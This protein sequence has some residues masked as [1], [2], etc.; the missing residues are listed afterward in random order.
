MNISL[1]ELTEITHRLE[2]SEAKV[3]RHE[4][5]VI[6]CKNAIKAILWHP[7]SGETLR[8]ASELVT[9]LDVE[10]HDP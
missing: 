10:D 6:Q 1:D 7:R 2:R 8:K 5:Q 4:Q 9:H 3:R